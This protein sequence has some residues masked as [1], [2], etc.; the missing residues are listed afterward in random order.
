MS[1]MVKNNQQAQ[2]TLKSIYQHLAK[3]EVN[4]EETPA[5]LGPWLKFNS[6]SEK[7]EGDF[8]EEANAYLRRA[9]YRK[10][11]EVPDKV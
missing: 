7:F 9:V 10:P 3:N 4:F 11:F 2:E 8:A 6:N 1:E 5:I